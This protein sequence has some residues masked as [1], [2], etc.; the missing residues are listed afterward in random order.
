MSVF[1]LFQR[2]GLQE[3]LN[4]NDYLLNHVLVRE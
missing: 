3:Y 2:L 1:V 4:G